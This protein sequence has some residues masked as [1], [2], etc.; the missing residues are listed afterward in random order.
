MK[1]VIIGIGQCGGRIADEF[2]RVQSRAMEFRR[3]EIILADVF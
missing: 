2:A 3:L 1:L